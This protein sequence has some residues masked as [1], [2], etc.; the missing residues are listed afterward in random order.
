MAAG[1]EAVLLHL[2]TATIHQ[3]NRRDY[4]PEQLVA[5][6][7]LKRDL[8]SWIERMQAVKPFV[9]E[10]EVGE[11]VG[12]ADLQSDGLVDF[13]FVA[14]DWQGHG[15]ARLLMTE[16]EKRADKAQLPM[17]Y[18][19]VSKTARPFFERNGFVV[20]QEQSA[21]T[22]GVELTNYLMRRTF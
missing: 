8:S 5:W 6:A 20:E 18:A 3:V 4:T 9:V 22:R 19:H 14:H 21:A 7:P 13:M 1:E 16:I 10:N 17:L 11:I 15:I 2:F 12:F